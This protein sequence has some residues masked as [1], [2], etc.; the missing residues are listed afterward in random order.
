VREPSIDPE[1]LA[2]F[3]DGRLD[4]GE[5][6]KLLAEIADSPEAL[7]L[8][9]DTAAVLREVELGDGVDTG[10]VDDGSEPWAREQGVAAAAAGVAPPGPRPVPPAPEPPPSRRPADDSGPRAVVGE[11]RPRAAGSAPPDGGAVRP[12]GRPA[13]RRWAVLAAAA[14]VLV[15]AGLWYRQRAAGPAPLGDPVT[16]VA[17][18]EAPAPAGGDALGEVPW[19]VTRGA[20]D[21][22][23][24][25][26]RAVRFGT[27]AAELALA[28]R[29]RDSAQ[30]R[31]LA[32]R[33]AVL[34]GAVGGSG[35]AVQVYREV[36]RAAG[37]PPDSLAALLRQ[38]WAAGASVVGDPNVGQED[39]AL[40]AWLAAARVAAAR[41]D[42]AFFRATPSRR[43]ASA[44]TARAGDL[45]EPARAAAARVAAAA[46]SDAAPD[47]PALARDAEALLAAL[48]R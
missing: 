16:L 18:I 21:A 20:G 11:I 33:T 24:D 42:A 10:S 22:L 13:L 44:L 4:E 23:T 48:G 5:R 6:A 26:A 17:L 37:A 2:A 39:A 45:D 43:A 40:G 19:P 9:A 38:A 36:E 34:V 32:A 14:V 1:R 46:A 15:A 30:V 8:L 29:A 47:W 35:P 3:L 41:R 25:R 31:A 28:A 7:D 27:R 12:A